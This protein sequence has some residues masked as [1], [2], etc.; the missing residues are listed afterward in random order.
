[1]TSKT[2]LW[3]TLSMV[4]GLSIALFGLL[5]D[6][7]ALNRLPD[8]AV[9]RIGDQLITANAYASALASVSADRRAPLDEE[10]RERVLQQLINEALLLAYSRDLDLPTHS[11]RVRDILIDEV[12]EL[13]RREA[14]SEA[15]TEDA[16]RRYFLQHRE[17]FRGPDLLHVQAI[18]TA[19]HAAAL[20]ARAKLLQGESI[21]AL[22][23]DSASISQWLP[24]GPLPL[25]KLRDYLGPTAATAAATLAP[26]EISAPVAIGDSYFLLRLQSRQ[27]ATYPELVD[28]APTVRSALQRERAESLMHERLQALR[29]RH[30]VTLATDAIEM[31][32]G[33]GE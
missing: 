18:Q 4:I 1:M 10:Q 31:V 25:D 33:A 24:D 12:L 7:T 19:S 26:G 11:P 2:T 20:Q 29:Q 28:I 13:L 14:A 8:G 6:D 3:L 22:P 15:V 17:R 9:A 32:D 23:V 5:D 16:I 21:N 30:A 27:K